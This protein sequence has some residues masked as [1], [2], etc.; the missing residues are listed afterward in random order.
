MNED[1]EVD[2]SKQCSYC[3][4]FICCMISDEIVQDDNLLFCDSDCAATYW[5]V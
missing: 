1:H 3:C 2:D 5:G 4:N